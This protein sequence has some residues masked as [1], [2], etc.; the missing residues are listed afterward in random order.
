M[1][2]QRIKIGDLGTVITGNTPARKDPDYYGSAYPFIKPTDIELDTRFTLSPEEYY[3]E[4]AYK[5]YKKSLIPRGSTCVV[6]I[7]SI[8]KK[9]TMAHTDCFINQAMN[10]VVPNDRFDEFYIFYLLKQNLYKVKALDSGTSSG[11]ENVSKSAFSSIEVDVHKN[12]DTQ[13]RIGFILSAYDNLIENNLRRIQLLEEAARCQYK[14]L[15]ENKAHY[16]RHLF[17]ERFEIVNGFAFKSEWY[18]ENG[19]PVLRTRDYSESVYITME[20][21]IFISE[22]L[23]KSFLKYELQPFDALLIMV[24]ASLGKY[25][26]VLPSDL[27]LLQNQN[28]WAIRE[29]EPFK[30]LK[31][32]KRFLL[33]EI[34][35][36]L[37]SMRTGAAR[38][39][40]RASFLYEME[41]YIPQEVKIKEFN[42]QVEV[43]MFLLDNLRQQNKRLR[44]ARDI[45]LPK[46]MSGEIDVSTVAVPESSKIV[47]LEAV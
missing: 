2:L 37:L 4:K 47:S 28:Q 14:Q 32:I 6:T 11:R 46:L 45:L 24:G 15:M 22:E 23:E 26:L 3:S 35:I 20:S 29:K 9:I 8:G 34:V 36:R 5:K 17:N 42:K 39:F 30:Y 43:H 31:Y 38:D 19:I 7:G 10:A 21:P 41:I 27:P 18:K 44:Q 33:E 16:N 40:F 25:G 12:K 1:K 13:K